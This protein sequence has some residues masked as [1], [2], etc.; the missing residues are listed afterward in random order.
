M[1][2]S[3][4]HWVSFLGYHFIFYSNFLYFIPSIFS[5][6][7]CPTVEWREAEPTFFPGKIWTVARASNKGDWIS[8]PSDAETPG[9]IVSAATTGSTAGNA[10]QR[11]WPGLP[12]SILMQSKLKQLKGI[13]LF[14]LKQSIPSAPSTLVDTA[15]SVC[16]ALKG[17][18][19]IA[20]FSHSMFCPQ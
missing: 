17:G 14:A 16:L 15:M 20:T 11:S 13:A 3:P 1:G 10:T 7:I 12:R 19:T 9:C 6:K 8:N 18:V 5:S 2:V 4:I